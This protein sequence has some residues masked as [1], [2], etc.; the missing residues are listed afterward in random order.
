MYKDCTL[1]GKVQ[2]EAKVAGGICGEAHATKVHDMVKAMKER[3][4]GRM[5]KTPWGTK[6]GGQHAYLS[7]ADGESEDTDPSE[8]A[9]ERGYSSMVLCQEINGQIDCMQGEVLDDRYDIEDMVGM[10][11]G[12]TSRRNH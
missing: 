6:Q 3:A 11:G 5:N 8:D 9:I 4:A 12:V 7:D 1:T 2:C 10:M